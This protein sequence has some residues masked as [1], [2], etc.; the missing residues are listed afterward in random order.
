MM[1]MLVQESEGKRIPLNLIY[2]YPVRWSKFSVL[3]D[4]MQ[5][6]YDA[7]GR[8]EWHS[9][10]TY[11]VKDDTL[12]FR[13]VD[14]GFSYDWLVYIGASTKRKESGNY[15]G[16]FGEGFKIAA[17][18]AMRDYGW[19]IEIAAKDWKLRVIKDGLK[20][21]HQWLPSLSYLVWE[22]GKIH[23]DNLLHIHP[24]LQEDI[25]I[26]KAVYLS[27]YFEE[28]ILF[29]E[30]IWS[31][32]QAAIFFRSKYPKPDNYPST[33]ASTGEGIIFTSYQAMG[34]CSYP[35]IFCLHNYRQNDRE[36]SGL[37]KIQV[38]DVIKRIAALMTPKASALV[39]E[40]IKDQWNTYP[41]SAYDFESWHPIVQCLTQNIARS[42]EH[43]TRWFQTHP[44]LVV[45]SQVKKNDIVSVNRRR[46][47]LAWIR[48][49][50]IKYR[51][52]QAGFKVLG[53]PV[54]EDI[55]DKHGGFSIAQEPTNIEADRIHL[56]ESL[57]ADLYKDLFGSISL[58]PCKVIENKRSV[59]RGMASCIPLKKPFVTPY[60]LKI[61]Y[62][63]PYIAMQRDILFNHRMGEALSVYLHEM[64]HMFGGDKSS[65]FSNALTIMI[66][67]LSDKS[68]QLAGFQIMWEA[69]LPQKHKI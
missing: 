29:G 24:F 22:N 60:G 7:V 54:L 47:A 26:L 62:R 15:A 32:P 52:V 9:R 68:D 30:K 19:Q 65:A 63:L 44:E 1:K 18:C 40:I 14:V 12:I 53:H 13:A 3:R 67:I 2:D 46:Q 64:A 39:L 37:Y 66:G 5:N 17:L 43:K 35:L 58:P 21:D 48:N 51:L 42:E 27:F 10:F 57:T 34:S 56:L 69:S 8:Q 4:F 50:G 59:W 31:S 25:P 41:R 20:V 11:E 33:Y 28:N 6:F 16:Y 36:R 23:K 49:A 55:C 61:R 45:A 38:I